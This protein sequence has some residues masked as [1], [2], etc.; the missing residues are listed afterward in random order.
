MI[1]PKNISPIPLSEL[2]GLVREVVD[3]ALGNQSFWMIAD[4]ANHNQ[5]SGR[6]Y[7]DLIEKDTTGIH[8]GMLDHAIP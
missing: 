4:V 1:S 5:N 7:F 3:Q 8:S 2:A 6:H